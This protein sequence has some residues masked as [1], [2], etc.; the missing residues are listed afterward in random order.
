MALICSLSLATVHGQEELIDK[1]DNGIGQTMV[2]V[3]P[4][5]F[6]MGSPLDE[7]G[8]DKDELQH[9]VQLTQTF[10]MSTTE[11][12][13]KQ[14]IAVMGEETWFLR[15]GSRSNYINPGDDVPAVNISWHQAVAFC[16]ALSKKEGKTYRLPTE[17]EWEYACRGGFKAAYNHVL[18]RRYPWKNTWCKER[19]KSTSAYDNLENSYVAREVAQFKPNRYGLFDMHGNVWEWCSDKYLAEYYEESPK[20]DPQGAEFEKEHVIRGGSITDEFVHHR[21]ASRSSRA[22]YTRHSTIGFR[23]AMSVESAVTGPA[24]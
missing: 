20:Y 3:K 23:V 8:R 24:K 15:G 6:E 18:D 1:F 4:G 21:S 10:Y 11:V 2:L 22:P 12:T 19:M 16:E 7:K 13:Q 14:W 9:D 5:L 17:A